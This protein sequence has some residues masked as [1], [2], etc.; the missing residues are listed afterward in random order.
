MLGYRINADSLKKIISKIAQKKGF[1]KKDADILSEGLVFADMRGIFSHGLVAFEKYLLQA[2]K[3]GVNSKS[4]LEVIKD[5][6]SII[7]ADANSQ[8]GIISCYKAAELAADKA[9]KTNISFVGVRNSNH[10][11]C[12]SFY[13]KKIA[14]SG[15][16]GI[17]MSNAAVTTAVT[18][19]IGRVI[20]NNPFSY[21][22][23]L[24]NNKC[25][26]FDIGMSKIAGGRINVAIEEGKEI[27][28]GCL[29]NKE[30]N[31][32]KNPSDFAKGGA[33]LTFGGHKGYGFALMIEILAGVITGAA[34]TND[35]GYWYKDLD[36]N[37]N[38]GHAIIAI[39]FDKII[40]KDDYTMRIKNL[41]KRIKNAPKAKGIHEIFL[42]GEIEDINEENSLKNGICF[43]HNVLSSLKNLA[44]KN[45]LEEDFRKIFIDDKY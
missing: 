6:G 41:V 27:P 42:P 5:V 1:N 22:I 13:S 7:I 33:L 10:F 9:K 44:I 23:P 3:G 31:D 2:E 34:V 32:T 8:L 37:C 17:V 40:A 18:G 39:N 20:G 25:L 14:K 11:G 15:L 36:R 24:Y 16:I 21:A 19:S 29:I 26:V 43:S 12:A 4:K 28:P 35:I 30:G 38:V 45:K